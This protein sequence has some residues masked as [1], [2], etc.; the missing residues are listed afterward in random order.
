MTSFQKFWLNLT[1]V[2]LVIMSEVAKFMCLAA[3]RSLE[4][5]L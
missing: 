4:V 5:F 1:I 3:C 2:A